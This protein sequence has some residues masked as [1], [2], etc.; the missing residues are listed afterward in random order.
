MSSLVTLFRFLFSTAILFC[1]VLISSCTNN[2]CSDTLYDVTAIGLE[3]RTWDLAT[4]GNSPWD[5]S[6]GLSVNR[7]LMKIDM[8]KSYKNIPD[9]DSEC[10]PKF[11]IENKAK[12]IKIFS[13]QGFNGALSAGQ[14]LSS[15]CLFTF[16]PGTFISVQDFIESYFNESNFTSF[17]FVFNQNPDLEATHNLRM[18]VEFEDGSKIESLPTEVLIKP[19]QSE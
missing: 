13:N 5:N 12:S 1:A 15:I 16:S 2:N 3:P 19:I 6:A 7:L 9:L 17:Y 11:R 14:D 8:T 4:N 18:V 10:L